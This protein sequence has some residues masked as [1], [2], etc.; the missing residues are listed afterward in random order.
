[1][2]IS[3]N[4]LD[5]DIIEYATNIHQ[6]QYMTNIKFHNYK[7]SY[8]GYPQCSNNFA[9]HSN[10]AASDATAGHYLK[11]VSCDSCDRSNYFRLEEPQVSWSGYLGGCGSL[12]CTGPENVLIEDQDGA[13]FGNPTSVISMNEHI[14]DNSPNCQVSVE[15][16]AFYCSDVNFAIAEF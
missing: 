9:M 5:Y 10:P 13:L 4:P 2:P 6:T 15:S 1:M 16:N 11:Q 7:A 12:D 8:S 14:G 3:G